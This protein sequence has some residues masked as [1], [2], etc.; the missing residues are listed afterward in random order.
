MT[1]TDLGSSKE[2]DI[3]WIMP[4]GCVQ[5]LTPQLMAF[6]ILLSGNPAVET[7]IPVGAITNPFMN[8]VRKSQMCRIQAALFLFPVGIYIV[9]SVLPNCVCFVA[10]TVALPPHLS[11]VPKSFQHPGV[12]AS[13]PQHVADQRFTMALPN[14][15]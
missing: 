10:S 1:Q 8:E 2:E 6:P 5:A 7:D 3:S 4:R 11:P 9:L 12:T 15:R 13:L 14:A